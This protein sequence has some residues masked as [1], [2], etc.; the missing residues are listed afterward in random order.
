MLL[1]IEGK[2][3]RN[4]ATAVIISKADADIGRELL[5]EGKCACIN[6]INQRKQEKANGSR[7]DT[8]TGTPR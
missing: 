5:A 8:T 4:L 2:P 1:T 7:P 6:H 3:V